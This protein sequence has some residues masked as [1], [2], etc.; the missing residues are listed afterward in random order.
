MG[1]NL[2]MH[3]PAAALGLAQVCKLDRALA[4]V[5]REGLDKSTLDA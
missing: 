5:V 2:R 3:E 4:A 1:P